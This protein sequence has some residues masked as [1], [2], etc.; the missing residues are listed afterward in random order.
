MDEAGSHEIDI[1]YLFK[2]G[3]LI[4]ADLLLLRA[5][6]NRTLYNKKNALIV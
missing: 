1:L 3:Y 6:L 5:L 2:E 4:S